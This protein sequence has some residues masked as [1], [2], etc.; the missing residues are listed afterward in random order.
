VYGPLEP[1]RAGLRYLNRLAIPKGE[2]IS[3]WLA[4]KL[5]APQLL[6]DLYA[7]QVRQTW[8]RAGDYDDISATI[9]LAKIDVGEP[10]IA[11]QNQ[12]VLLDIDVFN[13]WIEKAPKYE[14]LPAWFTRAHEVEN[15]IFEDCMTNDLRARFD[16]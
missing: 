4:F 10:T 6:H 8:A 11:V 2:D 1:K 7:F 14:N 15:Q 16:Q 3:Q 12:G 9:G 13:L 5:Q